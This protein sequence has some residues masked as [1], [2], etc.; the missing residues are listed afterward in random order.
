MAWF[1]LGLAPKQLFWESCSESV[2]RPYYF[3]K[4]N[5]RNGRP[6]IVSIGFSYNTQTD[7]SKVIKITCA[8]ATDKEAYEQH[9]RVQAEVYSNTLD[10]WKKVSVNFPFRVFRPNNSAIANMMPC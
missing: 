2:E 4:P 7:D 6:E 10:A 9:S 5:Y 8:K 3:S 1:A